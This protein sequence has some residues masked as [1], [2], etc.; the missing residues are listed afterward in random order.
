MKDIY[1]LLNDVD[2]D[3]S[4]FEEMEVSEIEK[5]RVKRNLKNAIHKKGNW[6]KKAI[7][8]ASCG[9]VCTAVLGTSFPAY[10]KNIPIVGDIF[11]FLDNGRT[12]LYDNYKDNANEID[13]TK[14]SNGVSITVNDAVFDGKTISLTYT[15]ESDRDLGE[16]IN[17]NSDVIVINDTF[18]GATGN[19]QVV[20]IDENT[21]IGQI[22][23][24]LSDFVDNPRDF[25]NFNL[26]IDRI[27]TINEEKINEVKGRWKFNVALDSI[28]VSTQVINETV[29]KEGVSANI[30]S[31]DVTPMSINIT[32]SQIVSK[33]VSDKWDEVYVD[34]KDDLGNVY[35][36]DGNGGHGDTNENITWNKTFGKLKDGAS[37]LTI[38]PKVAL[39]MYTKDNYGGVETDENGKESVIT[40]NTSGEG[41]KKEFIM[42]DII[43]ELTK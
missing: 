15:I 33:N 9:V 3:E 25:V 7:A 36:P 16:E 39:S 22:N 23:T 6:K 32:Y 40:H 8:V 29:N 1:E 14:V 20:K 31:L 26:S 4:E 35:L 13:I 41:E 2:I 28:K 5:I 43:I 37:K 21:Y 11:S 18:S 38:T 10:A 17:V 19:S 42:D 24:T 12:G 27:S 34:V 30:R